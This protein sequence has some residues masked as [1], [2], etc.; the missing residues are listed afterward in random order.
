MGKTGLSLDVRIAK[1]EIEA[2]LLFINEHMIKTI[3][4]RTNK[5]MQ[6]VHKKNDPD[7]FSLYYSGTNE[8][9]T[10]CLFRLLFFGGD[11]TKTLIS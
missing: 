11:Y 10:K 1:P 7:E 8:E 4:E 3:V 2:L 6:K 9:E 5:P